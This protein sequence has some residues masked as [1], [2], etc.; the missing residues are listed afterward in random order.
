MLAVPL[1]VGAGLQLAVCPVQS[2]HVTRASP[3][4]TNVPRVWLMEGVQ[5]Q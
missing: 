4:S 5:L 1:T 2:R 3:G